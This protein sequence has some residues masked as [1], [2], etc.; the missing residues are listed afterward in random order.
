MRE[1]HQ[2]DDS[3]CVVW[4]DLRSGKPSCRTGVRI[5]DFVEIGHVE[6][7]LR[8]YLLRISPVVLVPQCHHEAPEKE[9]A[10]EVLHPLTLLH[11]NSN[12][13]LT[14]SQLY[15]RKGEGST[16]MT[17]TLSAL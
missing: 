11:L 6:Y 16:L 14:M 3:D 12:L 13:N 15:C 4:S 5:S 17:Q 1:T 9:N 10:K 7:R 2:R 8:P